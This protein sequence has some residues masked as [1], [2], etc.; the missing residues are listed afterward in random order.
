MPKCRIPSG[1]VFLWYTVLRQVATVVMETSQL[2]LSQF[3]NFLTMSIE[4]WIRSIPVKIIS[5]S[6]CCKLVKLCHINL[7]GPVSL[8][9]LY[10]V[11]N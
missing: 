2:V 9:T 7:S 5:N 6:N 1:P 3:R 8:D 10:I 11:Y 4:D